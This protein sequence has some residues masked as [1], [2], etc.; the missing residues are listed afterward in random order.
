[1]GSKQTDQVAVAIV[2]GGIGG[3]VAGVVL[4][5]AGIKAHVYEQA[6]AYADVGGHLTMDTA[7][8]EVLGRFG[9]DSPFHD[10]SCPLDGME[11]RSMGTGDVVARF[12]I[13]DLGAMGVDD[14]DRQGS[15]VVYAFQRADFLSMLM[16]RLPADCMHTGHRL[17]ALNGSENGATAVFANGEEVAAEIVIGA[18]GVKSLAREMFDA[19]EFSAAGHSVLRTL[20]P[21]TVLPADLPNDRMRFWDGWAF[22]NKE[23]NEGV[24]VL[25]VPVR[26]G[27]YVSI[28]LQFLGGD[29]LEDC[30]PMDLPFERIMQRYP[31]EMD[32]LI[33][34]MLDARVESISA[35]ALFDRRVAEKWVDQ[36]IAILG[37]AAHSMRPNLGQGACQSVHDV[38]ELMKAIEAHGLTHEALKAYES[39]RA[40]YVKS[41]VDVA[42][43]VKIDPKAWKDKK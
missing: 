16:A 28:D 18:D 14:P 4:N 5:Q 22:G 25:T 3:L 27:D 31:D 17:T 15:R 29:Q 26:G 35:H 9:L 24:H 11:V 37:D 20:C 34:K 43:N 32:P 1:M 8:I 19:A 40:P 7:A 39:V 6:P 23:K 36:R 30:N 38:G 21:A 33:N 12:P 13:P 2:G 10:M 41:I 42:M